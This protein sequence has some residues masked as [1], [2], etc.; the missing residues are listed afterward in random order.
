MNKN[1]PIFYA[2]INEADEGIFAIS[3]VDFPATMSDFV[4]FNEDKVVEQFS[5][6][7][8]DQHI[9]SGVVM[10][11]NTPIY[12]RNKDG[13]EYYIVYKPETIRFMAEKLFS[14]N[15]QN[16]ID[17]LHNGNLIDGIHLVELFIKDSSKGVSPS[18]LENVTEGSLIATYKVRNEEI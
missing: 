13:M 10:S 5:V 12:R 6:Q 14:D 9:I 18:Y 3:L 15:N 1:L 16:Q 4:A 8:E 7:D 2:E 17:V 11:A